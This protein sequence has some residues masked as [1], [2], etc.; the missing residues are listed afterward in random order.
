MDE[1]G[2]R[3]S[4]LLPSLLDLSEPLPKQN[5]EPPEFQL[6]HLF[7][8]DTPSHHI[9]SH[10]IAPETRRPGLL[11]VFFISGCAHK[12]ASYAAPP[13][14]PSSSLCLALI[15][16]LASLIRAEGFATLDEVSTM[17]RYAL[18][19]FGAMLAADLQRYSGESSRQRASETLLSPLPPYT[20]LPTGSS[21]RTAPRKFPSVD[22]LQ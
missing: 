19:S 15:S 8:S 5:F 17:H 12:Q 11:L 10:R 13:T 14:P 16:N 1:P 18:R 2:T 4:R 6:Q 7:S 22:I 20:P 9:T 3:E 21:L